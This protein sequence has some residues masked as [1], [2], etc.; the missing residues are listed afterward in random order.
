MD[1]RKLLYFATI[2]EQGSLAKAGRHLGVSQPALSKS[3][4]RLEGELGFKLMER[5]AAG[6]VPTASGELIYTHARLI[7]D[8]MNLAS[9]RVKGS[10]GNSSVVTFATLPSLSS[11]VIPL[12]VARWKER[13]PEVLVR[14][15]EKVQVELLL[16]LLRGEYDFIVGQTEFFDVV[17]DGLKQRVLF[18]DRLCVFARPKHSLFM[19]KKLVWADLAKF[20]WVSPM[21]GWSQ[22]TVLEKL[23]ASENIESPQQLVECGSIDFTKSLVAASDHLALLPAHAVTAAVSD[24]VIKALPITVSALKRDIAVIFRERSPLLSV[25]QALIDDIEEIG[26]DLSRPPV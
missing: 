13:Y 7:R 23:V 4:D 16:G 21:V 1:P 3:M 25:S 24:G 14:V 5:S 9:A 22:R 8:E 18:R 19:K 26:T 10:E 15:F 12:A 17:L 11:S 20:P 6:I 2:V